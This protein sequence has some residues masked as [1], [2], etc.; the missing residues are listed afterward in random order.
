V[1]D[2]TNQ[3][4]LITGAGSGI[5]FALAKVAAQRGMHLVLVDVE[6]AAL[7]QAKTV[8]EAKLV[9]SQIIRCFTVDVSDAE[10]MDAMAA[11]VFA[12][13]A[14]VDL[15]FNNAGVGGSGAIWEQDK[16]YWEWMLGVNLWGVI[17]AVHAFTAAM[18]ERDS[19][20][21][22][23]TASVAGLV[24]AADTGPYTV[25]KHAVVALSEV[26]V[27]DLRKRNSRVGVS[28]ICPSFV[29]TKIYA[30]ER[31]RPLPASLQHD[32]HYH[33]DQA[34]LA[35]AASEF[36]AHTLSPDR[37]A[38]QVFEAIER[39]EFYILPHP[40][41]SRAAIAQRFDGIA[42]GEARPLRGPEEYPFS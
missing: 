9:A 11:E 24:S 34:A 5:G 10:Q 13:F 37:V 20:Y 4:A 16:A 31:N 19:G 22:I 8:L 39:R 12:E 41:G 1:L 29:N 25:S 26:L 36:F 32:E 18:V 35:E 14:H 6:A 40:E 7:E 28:I 33:R 15:L 30:A 38:E 27:A 42:A 3:V 17:N 21:I 23:N 2:L